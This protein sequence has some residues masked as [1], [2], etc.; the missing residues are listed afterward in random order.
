MNFIPMVLPRNFLISL[1]CCSIPLALYYF[2]HLAALITVCCMY[3][4]WSMR[5]NV[6][7]TVRLSPKY[8]AVGAPF[9]NPSVEGEKGSN[10]GGRGSI[11]ENTV[12]TFLTAYRIFYCFL[13]RKCSHI[14]PPKTCILL[15]FRGRERAS[16]S[17]DF[18]F[19]PPALHSSHSSPG[20]WTAGR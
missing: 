16:Y 2:I 4:N 12:I 19:H 5:K 9:F 8:W 7:S 6:F 3:L 17:V 13:Q 14:F 1:F 11:R 10:R 20:A 15:L 18:T